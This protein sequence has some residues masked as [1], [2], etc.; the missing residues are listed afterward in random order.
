MP[1]HQISEVI[2][3]NEAKG[4]PWFNESTC[5]CPLLFAYSGRHGWLTVIYAIFFLHVICTC[6]CFCF[7]RGL[8][9]FHILQLCFH[10]HHAVLL[11]PRQIYTQLAVGLSTGREK[12]GPLYT[13]I[14]MLTA[15]PGESRNYTFIRPCHYAS[16]GCVQTILLTFVTGLDSRAS[17][18]EHVFCANKTFQGLAIRQE[19]L[20]SDLLERTSVRLSNV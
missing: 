11:G 20:F 13:M 7:E 16:G 10:I 5:F 1:F 14:L 6:T 18:K 17:S 4:S 19:S 8:H 2:V 12:Q 3:V 15:I 9:C